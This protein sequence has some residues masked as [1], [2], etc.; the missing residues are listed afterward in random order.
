MTKKLRIV[1]LAFCST[2]ACTTGAHLALAQAALAQAQTDG[3]ETTNVR[4]PLKKM[5]V[6]LEVR[7]ALSALP[8]TLREKASVYVLDPAKGY[9][10]ERAGSNGQ[11]C[12]VGRTE[13]K[14]AD[15]RNDVYDPICYDA[16]GAKNHM[17]V[18][19]DVAELRAKGVDP[20]AMKKEIEARFRGGVYKAPDHPG[21]SYMTAPLMR[22][23]MSLDP[24]DK[25]S[26][27]TMSMPHIMYYAPNVSGADIGGMPCPPC[28][29]YPFVFEPGPHGYIIQRLGDA[30]SAKIVADEAE[31]VSD[32][33]S[34][35]SVLCLASRDSGDAHSK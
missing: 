30:E 25:D 3:N 22:S 35:R 20:E 31:L 8:P 2:G 7:L 9:M 10:P 11:S 29:P 33:C 18:W 16:T 21:M 27:M 12:F 34:Y 28:A 14:F 26:V 13:W 19:F 23:Y 6:S 1:L 17:R 24:K 5:P 15:Y 4:G 32:L